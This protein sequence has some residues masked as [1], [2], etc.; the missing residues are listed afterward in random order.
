MSVVP[1]LAG[2]LGGEAGFGLAADFGVAAGAQLRRAYRRR[3]DDDAETYADGISHELAATGTVSPGPIAIVTRDGGT[4]QVAVLHREALTPQAGSAIDT[5]TARV[6]AKRLR[7]Q[8]RLGT[9]EDLDSNPSDADEQEPP[10]LVV[11]WVDDD[12]TTVADAH[13][14]GDRWTSHAA[15]ITLLLE[16]P[17]DRRRRPSRRTFRDPTGRAFL[18]T[19]ETR[20]R[21]P[22]VRLAAPPE[23]EPAEVVLCLWLGQLLDA[24]GNAGEQWQAA[25][26]EWR[27]VDDDFPTSVGPGGFGRAFSLL[28]G[29]TP[30][31]SIGAGGF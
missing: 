29:S 24:H 6:G 17:D 5:I 8:H 14:V 12:G 25:T 10:D 16:V 13:R 15:G 22:V 9:G 30:G 31:G 1:G 26:T 20:R 7:L 2:T 18:L 23:L 4:D 21:L 27:L 19:Y 11:R 28:G 3:A